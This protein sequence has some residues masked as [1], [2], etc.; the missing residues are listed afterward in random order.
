MSLFL[1]TKESCSHCVQIKARLKSNNIDYT[2]QVIGRD[3][4]SEDFTSLFPE[5]RTVPFAVFNRTPIGGTK[6]IEEWINDYG[7]TSEPDRLVPDRLKEVFK[8]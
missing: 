7:Q 3:I 5:V 1:Y 8:L 4:L 6:K 2:E